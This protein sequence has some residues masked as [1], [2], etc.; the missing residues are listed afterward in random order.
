MNAKEKAKEL[1][2]KMY[3]AEDQDGFH[4]MN[5]YRAKQC[6]LIAVNLAIEEVVL[7]EYGNPILVEKRLFYLEGIKLEIEKL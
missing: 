2:A 5:K 1:V 4:S 7:F 3:F 6:A